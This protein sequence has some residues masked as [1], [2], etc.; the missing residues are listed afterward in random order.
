MLAG[1]P[2]SFLLGD[3]LLFGRLRERHVLAEDAQNAAAVHTALKPA[4]CAVN[5]L[6][7]PNFDSDCQG[8]SSPWKTFR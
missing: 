7:V 2:L 4:Q 6:F 1:I 3:A 5:R 8:E